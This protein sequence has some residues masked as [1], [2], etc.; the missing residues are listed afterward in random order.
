[1][2]S[3]AYCEFILEDPS[4]QIS[5]Q[6]QPEIVTIW[7]M[8]SVSLVCKVITLSGLHCIIIFSNAFLIDVSG[9]KDFY[10]SNKIIY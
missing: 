9:P 2:L 3:T 5:T 1:M 7:T 4:F 10:I 8:F 6:N